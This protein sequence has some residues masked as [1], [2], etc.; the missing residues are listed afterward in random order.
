MSEIKYESMDD[1]D[2]HYY[3]PDAR[4]LKYSEISNYETIESLLPKHKSYVILYP[5]ASEMSGHWVSLTRYDKTIEFFDS[6][7]GKPDSPFNWNTSKFKSNKRYLSELL[8]KT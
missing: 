1:Q 8:N 7:G 5:V 2:I 3:L 6:C 4:I